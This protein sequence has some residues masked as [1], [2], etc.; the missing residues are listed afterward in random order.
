MKSE[1]NDASLE[2]QHIAFANEDDHN[3]LVSENDMS[4]DVIYVVDPQMTNENVECIEST[5]V[6]ECTPTTILIC[7]P[8]FGNMTIMDIGAIQTIDQDVQ[9]IIT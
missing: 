7:N 9:T 4:S 1:S 6:N 5:N 8:N 3:Y 2:K